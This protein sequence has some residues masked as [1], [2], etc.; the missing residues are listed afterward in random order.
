MTVFGALFQ[1][2]MKI[3]GLE[4]KQEFWQPVTL[5]TYLTLM[6]FEAQFQVNMKNYGLEQKEE[7]WKPL[8]G[9]RLP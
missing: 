8:Q 3:C 7:L 9:K 4:L 5:T 6:D 1:V 2:K